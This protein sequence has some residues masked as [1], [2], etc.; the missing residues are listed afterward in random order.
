MKQGEEILII[1]F[2][3]LYSLLPQA[4]KGGMTFFDTAAFCTLIPISY[5][6]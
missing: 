3:T 5:F 6:L 4:K 2:L 1:F